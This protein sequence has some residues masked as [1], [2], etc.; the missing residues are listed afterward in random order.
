[1]SYHRITGHDTGCSCILCHR[2]LPATFLNSADDMDWLK[3]VFA[4]PS[5]S[6]AAV[7][8]GNADSP[9]VIECYA[10]PDPLVTDSPFAV[11]CPL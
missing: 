10:S 5:E 7:F 11:F 8:Y 6:Q 4:V 1:M 9:E 3:E 2:N